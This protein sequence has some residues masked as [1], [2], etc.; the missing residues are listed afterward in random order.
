M[1]QFSVNG[2][3]DL[4]EDLLAIEELPD[5][6]AE[7]M[8]TAEAEVVEEAQVYTGMKMGVYRTGETL[9][10]ITHGK[11]KRGKDGDRS[12]YVYP[13]GTNENGD[14]N[15]EVAFINEYGAPARGIE[16]RPFI[17]TANESAADTAVNAVAD[18][19]DEFLKAQN[20]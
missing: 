14:R 19:Y 17:R 15:A 16:P 8:L 3:D 5:E 4:M 20:L 1:A 13:Q 18:V 12:M 10:S 11:M 7:K 6:T 2:L 9:R